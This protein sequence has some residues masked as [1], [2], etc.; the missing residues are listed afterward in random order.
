MGQAVGTLFDE[1]ACGSGT[2]AIGIA[3]AAVA[4]KTVTLTVAQPSGES[5]ASEA[6]YSRDTGQR[7]ESAIDGAVTV[8]YD[9]PLDLR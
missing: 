3:A 7:R 5:I 9:G 1:T 8:I 2:S 6:T 4:Q